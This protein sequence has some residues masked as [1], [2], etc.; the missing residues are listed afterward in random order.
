MDRKKS[1]DAIGGAFWLTASALIVKLLGLIY[2][3]PLTRF[4]GEEGMGYFNSAYTVYA[5]FYLLCSAGVPKAVMMVLSEKDENE[6]EKCR[7]VRY[8]LYSF[9]MLGLALT[10][11]FI[12][13]SE[14]LS[15]MIGNSRARA[16][17]ICVAPSVL[18][19]SISG[20]LRG[21]LSDR[22]SFSSIAI[23]QL[24]EGVAKLALGLIFAGIA[25]RMSMSLYMI[26]AMT[27]LG[28]TIGAFFGMIYL[29]FA[30]KIPI[31]S[32]KTRQK[33]SFVSD[34]GVLKSI[35]HIS[36]PIT[37]SAAVMSLSGIL[38]LGMIV[39]RLT[40]LGYSERDAVAL[41]G[42]YTTLTVPIFNLAIALISSIP[43]AF[44]PLMRQAHVRGS[45]S[46][47]QE[48]MS[49]SFSLSAL[50]SAPIMVGVAFY[51]DEIL[52]LLFPGTNTAVGGALLRL[53]APAILLSSILLVLNSAIE[54]VGMV[55]VPVISM[56]AGCTAKV[57]V[58]YFLIGN[59]AYGIS[60][61]PI[62]TVVCYAVACLISACIFRQKC[63]INAPFIRESILPHVCAL[64]SVVVSKI[65][66]IYV[67]K[68][69]ISYGLSLMI[70][71]VV[72]AVIYALLAWKVGILTPAR[73]CK[74]SKYTNLA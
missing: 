55:N 56:L 9:M 47:F 35:L 8:A 40:G 12:L 24:I 66:Y 53:L 14:P 63:G 67:I 60:G 32:I 61:A 73:L 13:F 57:I 69:T 23:S 70:S 71:I 10:C 28:V 30:S 38:D 18:F 41:Y 21:Y 44:L 52:T 36:V 1:K 59:G 65:L 4:L 5:F 16:T 58:G 29:A 64:A 33:R 31:T 45:R 37:L 39:R 19:V 43:V 68:D 62:G 11:A 74:M 2:K 27:I 17:M 26:S 3:V 50:I 34:F 7:T 25:T 20:V 42:N 51:A 22:L 48:H 15:R 6:E 54:S 49:T 46:E 72:A